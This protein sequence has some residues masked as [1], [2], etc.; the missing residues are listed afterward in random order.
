MYQ[1]YIYT[2]TA[3]KTKS[4]KKQINYKKLLTKKQKCNII[5]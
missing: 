2:Y 1:L 3:F 4:E 5:R